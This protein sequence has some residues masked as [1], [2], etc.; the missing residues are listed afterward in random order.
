MWMV[1]FMMAIGRKIKHRDMELIFIIMGRGIKVNGLMIIN[2]GKDWK[3]G[4]MAVAIKAL[5][6]KAR[7]M[8]KANIH[9]RMAASIMALGSTIK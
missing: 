5:I 8:E 1:I 9:G 2:M 6:N 7:K 4:L 3:L